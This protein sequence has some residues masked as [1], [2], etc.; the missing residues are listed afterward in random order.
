MKNNTEKLQELQ[1]KRKQIL[2]GFQNKTLKSF[3]AIKKLKELSEQMKS[4]RRGR[5]RSLA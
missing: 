5:G 3:E 2:I 1:E 4:V